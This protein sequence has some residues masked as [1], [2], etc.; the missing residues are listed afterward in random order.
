MQLEWDE[1][2]NQYR[3]LEMEIRIILARKAAK[4]EK[5][6]IPYQALINLYLKDHIIN[7]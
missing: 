5:V 7:N 4:S 3:V 6:G 1:H 2:K